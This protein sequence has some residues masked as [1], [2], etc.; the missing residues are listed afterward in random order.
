MVMLLT[1]HEAFERNE[2]F[3]SWPPI[4]NEDQFCDCMA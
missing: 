1:F 4:A 3:D 2:G